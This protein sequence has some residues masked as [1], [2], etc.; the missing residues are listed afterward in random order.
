[1]VSYKPWPM[2]G[3]GGLQDD[4]SETQDMPFPCSCCF[5]PCLLDYI[6]AVDM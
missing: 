1:M 2:I 3:L 5:S 6:H 4:M